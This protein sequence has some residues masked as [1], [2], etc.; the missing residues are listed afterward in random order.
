MDVGSAGGA[1]DEEG[2]GESRCHD[3]IAQRL[4]S[5]MRVV[6]MGEGFFAVVL[7]VAA[8]AASVCG[9]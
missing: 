8:T 4:V 1:R 7:S 3:V 2:Q 9:R 6:T 5:A